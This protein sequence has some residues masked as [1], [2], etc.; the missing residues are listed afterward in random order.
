MLLNIV[1]GAQFLSLSYHI[2]NHSLVSYIRLLPYS[3]FLIPLFFNL[4]FEH[5]V[6]LKTQESTLP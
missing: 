1:D 4:G 3:L 6:S 2:A 5:L